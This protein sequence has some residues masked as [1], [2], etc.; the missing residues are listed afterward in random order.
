MELKIKNEEQIKTEVKQNNLSKLKQYKL[1]QK[2]SK[3]KEN[4]KI[5]NLKRN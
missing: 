1:I 4:E 5:L 2:L 3:A